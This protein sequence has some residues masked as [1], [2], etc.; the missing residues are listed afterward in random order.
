MR[1]KTIDSDAGQVEGRHADA[2]WRRHVDMGVASFVI[3]V[4]ALLLYLVLTPH[5]PDRGALEVFG[6]ALVVWWLAV[7]GPIGRRAVRTR[8]RRA[9]FMIWSLA[10]L[11]SIATAIGLDG[12]SR[13]PLLVMLVLPVLFGALVYPPL[14]VC[15]LAL[16]AEALFVALVLAEPA[17]G[18]SRSL[19]TGVMLALTGGISVMAS[20]NRLVQERARNRLG[21]RLHEMATHDGLTGCLSYLSFRR[22]LQAEAARARRYGN[23]FSLVIADLDSFKTINDTYGHD[24]GDAVLRSVAQA[25]LSGARDSDVV[26]RI[27][28]DEFAILLPE[29]G[30]VRSEQVAQRLQFHARNC[31]L[32]VEATVSY[33]TATWRGPDDDLEDVFRRADQALYSAKHAGRDRIAVWA[34]ALPIS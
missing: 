17:P 27:G 23:A 14:D 29:T 5:G 19:V 28:G 33:G 34:N 13:S 16:S 1:R 30:S 12:G 25:F 31:R 10:T 32:P 22:A 6:G 7:F 3:G 20:I 18:A 11:A 2:F 4:F 26:G 9:F 15:V 8:Y 21:A 24:V